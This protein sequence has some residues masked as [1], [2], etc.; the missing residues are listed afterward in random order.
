MLQV[1]DSIIPHLAFMS[2]TRTPQTGG[3]F[4]GVSEWLERIGGLIWGPWTA[5]LVLGAGVWLSC[6]TGWVQITGLKK[7][8]SVT[9]GS[10]LRSRKKEGISPFQSATA[11][12]AGSLGTGN[13]VGVAAALTAGGPGAIFW[14]WAAAVP[15]MAVAYAEN[16]LGMQHRRKQPDGRWLGGPMLYMGSLPGMKHLGAVW[17][18]ICALGGLCL[19]C[20]VQVN[21]VAVSASE[22]W[23]I[24]PLLT[25]AVL[26]AAAAPAILGGARTVT[27]LTERLVPFMAAGYILVCLGVII[28][29]M[30]RLPGVLTEIFTEAFAPRSVG[31]GMLGVMLTGIRRGVFTHEAGMGTSVLIH[32]TADNA[33]PDEQG[34]WSIFEVFCDTVIMCS[35]TAFAILVTGAD[36]RGEGAAMTAEAF[37]PLLGG[38]AEGFS[39]AAVLLFAFATVVGWSCCGERAFAFLLGEQAAGWYRLVYVLLIIPGCVMDTGAVWA[40]ADILNAALM[41]PNMTAV[42]MHV[43]SGGLTATLSGGRCR[44]DAKSPDAAGASG[45]RVM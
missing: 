20:M 21:S 22:A 28:I 30:K 25:G 7:W 27:R 44:K 34:C 31:G 23:D 8:W 14:M 16:V 35:L 12:L 9:A 26:A 2:T 3:M 38:W 43:H 39:A 33:S 40:A 29:N 11:A 18:G 15:S 41:I 5:G 24:S 1:P 19:G 17:A 37:R 13:I 6:R 42:V 10:L 36:H 45:L 4:L 32:C